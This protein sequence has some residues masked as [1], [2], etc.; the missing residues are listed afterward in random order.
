MK[1]IAKLALI[2][3]VVAVAATAVLAACQD[4]TWGPVG[5]TD[6]E[7]A[8]SGNGSVAVAQG[9]TVY[10][11]NGK[12]D[13]SS[14]TEPENNWFGQAGYKG[15]IMKGALAADGSVRDVA[16]VVPK[17]F[18]NGQAEGGLYVFGNWIYYT[19]PSTDTQSDGT[20]LTSQQDFYRTRT[21]GTRTQL[22]TTLAA[23]TY[24]YI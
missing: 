24:E 3:L 15:S 9:N 20:V 5:T 2:V 19:S 14:I 22:V 4:Y 10:F 17:M 16:V 1:K 23:N 8:V 7:A 6:P 12:G 21:D 11:V 18:Y 13:T